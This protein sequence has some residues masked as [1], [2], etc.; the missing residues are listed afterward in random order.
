MLILLVHREVAWHALVDSIQKLHEFSA[1]VA[2]LH[3]TQNLA[4]RDVERRKQ[5]QRAMTKV[6][7]R[8]P[9][10]RVADRPLERLPRQSV[11][12]TPTE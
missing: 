4:R 1:P 12:R 5:I 10:F 7:V 2:S 6:V 8:S 11:P 3:L 9:P